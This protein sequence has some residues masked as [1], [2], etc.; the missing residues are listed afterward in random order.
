MAAKGG[1]AGLPKGKDEPLSLCRQLQNQVSMDIYE[2]L[3]VQ[4]P[5]SK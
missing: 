4:A 2:I 1:P 3:A 5:K